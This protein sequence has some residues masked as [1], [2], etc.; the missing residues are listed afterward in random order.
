MFYSEKK[1]DTE[2]ILSKNVFNYIKISKPG[3]EKMLI[4]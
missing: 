1:R 4:Q 2:V 3:S